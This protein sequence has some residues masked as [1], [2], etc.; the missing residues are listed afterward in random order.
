MLFL[1]KWGAKILFFQFAIKT[2]I[3]F[4]TRQMQSMIQKRWGHLY[5]FSLG[6]HA[7]WDIWSL[8]SWKSGK[9]CFWSTF[10]D[11]SGQ[12]PPPIAMPHIPFLHLSLSFLIEISA[13]SLN[14]IQ[15]VYIKH[16]LY[17]LST[18]RTFSCGHLIRSSQQL[19]KVKDD[20]FYSPDGKTE[21]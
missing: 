21:I 18:C 9:T 4:F 19:R 15:C 11:T 12:S 13:W 10:T 2:A 1:D 7:Q 3:E 6:H 8:P 16:Q 20:S 14:E 5:L 17:T